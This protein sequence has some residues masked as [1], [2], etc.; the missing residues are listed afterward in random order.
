MQ[1]SAHLEAALSWPWR[2]GKSPDDEVPEE[3]LHAQ[4]INSTDNVHETAKN[5][6][7][8]SDTLGNQKETANQI[9]EVE[10]KLEK[11][12]RRL[13]AKA[14]MSKQAND[15]HSARLDYLKDRKDNLSKEVSEL[16]DTI[17]ALDD[18]ISKA[19]TMIHRLE[20][21]KDHLPTAKEKAEDDVAKARQERNVARSLSFNGNAASQQTR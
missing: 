21:K 14:N 7:T 17:E 3:I 12:K 6:S 5:V 16:N 4:E 19:T 15:N 8:L 10:A 13:D 9:D 1:Q 20:I 18:N 11:K 2:R